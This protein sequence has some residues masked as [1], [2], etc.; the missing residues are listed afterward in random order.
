MTRAIVRTRK[1]C[2]ALFLAF[3]RLKRSKI[4]R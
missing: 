3:R 4:L 2:L 1:A